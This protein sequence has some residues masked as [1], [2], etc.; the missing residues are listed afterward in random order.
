M[1]GIFT[2][3]YHKNPPNVGKYTIHGSYGFPFHHSFRPF[4]RKNSLNRSE[5][6]QNIFVPRTSRPAPN[7]SMPYPWQMSCPKNHGISKLVVWRSQNP[8][9]QIQTPEGPVILR[10]G[11]RNVNTESRSYIFLE[12]NKTISKGKFR[13]HST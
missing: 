5:W 8:A 13:I 12:K 6:L 9:I 7:N 2:Y 1:Y 11:K 4:P 10:A 3:I